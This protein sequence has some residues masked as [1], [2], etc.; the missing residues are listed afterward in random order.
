MQ[1]IN[2]LQEENNREENFVRTASEV[3]LIIIEVS[4]K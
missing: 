4:S 1:K 2:N 3:K